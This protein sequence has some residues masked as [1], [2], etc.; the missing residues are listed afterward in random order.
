MCEPHRAFIEA[1]LRLGRNATA[2]YQELLDAHGFAGLYN[3]V[4]PWY[5]IKTEAELQ[6]LTRFLTSADLVQGASN[7]I[8]FERDAQLKDHVF[9]FFST[10]HSPESQANC[11]S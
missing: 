5:A 6:P 3:S 10:N 7:T 2:I 8:V 11:Q 4:K 9:K 1:Q